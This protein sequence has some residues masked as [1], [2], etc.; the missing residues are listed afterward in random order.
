M[1]RILVSLIGLNDQHA[2]RTL[3]FLC[4]LLT[5]DKRYQQMEY[6]RKSAASHEKCV[7]VDFDRVKIGIETKAIS[8]Q[9]P[10][11]NETIQSLIANHECDVIICTSKESKQASKSLRNL[12]SKGSPPY[13]VLE[14]RLGKFSNSTYMDAQYAQ[15]LL[16]SVNE[17]LTHKTPQF[18]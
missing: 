18:S 5:R 10:N 9:D 4:T 8:T 13:Q 1:T 12:A 16:N 3:D 15:E 2:L 17:L 14:K 11:S 6:I 7:I